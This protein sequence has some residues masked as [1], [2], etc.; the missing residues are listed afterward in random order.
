MPIDFAQSQPCERRFVV[1][2]LTQQIDIEI[3]L[4]D[5]VV[6]IRKKAKSPSIMQ[7]WDTYW[8]ELTLDGIV[9]DNELEHRQLLEDDYTAY[10][11]V[12]IDDRWIFFPPDL[13][14]STISPTLAYP[15]AWDRDEPG[16]PFV[17]A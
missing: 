3:G 9:S 10:T 16:P 1:W 4:V 8:I 11:P 13:L 2:E 5:F 14:T 15:V 12:D 6:T 7:D 17:P